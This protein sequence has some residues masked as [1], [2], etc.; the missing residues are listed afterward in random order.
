MIRTYIAAGVLLA[1]VLA[2]AFQQSRL[3]SCRVDYREARAANAAD[4]AEWQRLRA[5][6]E[7]DARR[8]L[9][10]AVAAERQ[11]AADRL[12]G[13]AAARR[14]AQERATAIGQEAD[15]LRRRLAEGA[16]E[17]SCAA[18]M[19]QPLVCPVD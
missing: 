8:R 10:A 1:V 5:D 11:A 2:F 15:R 13:E 16:A 7:S 19:E 18:Q 4:S 9:E 14:A 6:A 3:N 17:P 12:A